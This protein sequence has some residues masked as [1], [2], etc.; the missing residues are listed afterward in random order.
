MNVIAFPIEE[1]NPDRSGAAAL[2]GDLDALADV[3]HA[4]VHTGAGVSFVV[5][6][7]VADP[8][9][10]ARDQHAEIGRAHV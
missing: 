9:V 2:D 8:A 3:L 6:F 10:A 4:V 1:W 7:S 5:P